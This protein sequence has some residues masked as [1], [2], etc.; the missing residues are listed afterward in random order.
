MKLLIMQFSPVLYYFIPL[1]SQYSP[2]HCSKMHPVCVSLNVKD[3]ISHP[4]RTAH[5][6]IVLCILIFTF[7]FMT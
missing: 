5:K 3:Q 4:Y 7:L 2:Q 1:W 6:I